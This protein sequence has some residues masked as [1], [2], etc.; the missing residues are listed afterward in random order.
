MSFNLVIHP[1]HLNKQCMENNHPLKERKEVGVGRRNEREGKEKKKGGRERWEERKKRG[2]G[3]IGKRT[4]LLQ[5][6]ERPRVEKGEERQDEGVG[7]RKRVD[8]GRK[9]A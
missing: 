6:R 2:R 3:R 9:E 4:V 5:F 7:G 8:R 1:L